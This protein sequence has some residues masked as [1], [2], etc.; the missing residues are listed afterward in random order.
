MLC[1]L[2]AMYGYQN[3]RTDDVITVIVVIMRSCLSTIPHLNTLPEMMAAVKQPL[4][5]WT[6]DSVTRL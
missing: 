3:T 5:P 1:T 6:D 2:L 4:S